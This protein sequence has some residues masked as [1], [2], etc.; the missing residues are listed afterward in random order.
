MRKLLVAGVVVAFGWLA[1]TVV[2]TAEEAAKP[3]YTIKQVMKAGHAKGALKD[4]VAQGKATD[5][6]KVALIAYYEALAANKPKKGS[7]E[8]WKEK[9]T[10]LIAAAKEAAEGKEG[11]GE[12]LMAASNC[13]AC[14]K[15]H[16]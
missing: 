8:S 1:L 13:M 3:K 7:E 6:E 16:K 4:K 2:T 14:H 15:E 5:E 12:K 10:A 11:A 9:T